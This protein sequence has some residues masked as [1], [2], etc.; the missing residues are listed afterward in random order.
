M[1]HFSNKTLSGK[2][3]KQ[4]AFYP[5]ILWFGMKNLEW[6]FNHG[7]YLYRKLV[8]GQTRTWSRLQKESRKEDGKFNMIDIIISKTVILIYSYLLL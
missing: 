1:Q 2:S 5:K 4:T 3:S 7:F 6:I 8:R